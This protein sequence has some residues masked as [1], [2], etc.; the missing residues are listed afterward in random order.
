MLSPR[1]RPLPEVALAVGGVAMILGLAVLVSTDMSAGFDRGVIEL[2]RAPEL[3]GLLAPLRAVTELGSTWA[4][5]A[6]AVGVLAIGGLLGMWRHGLAGALTVTLAA[7]AN[8]SFKVVM[9]RQR[10]DLLDPVVV[11][12]GFSFPSGHS[13]T[14]MVAYGVLAVLVWRSALPAPVRVAVV[15]ASAVLIGLI[16]LSRVWLGVHY[17]TDVIAGWTVGAVLVVVYAAVSRRAWPAPA[18]A[19]AGAGRAGPRS[20]R[21]VPG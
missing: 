19:R 15:V 21:P 3:R 13:A 17:P 12:H 2:V 6:V 8:S 20:D 7:I 14:G 9:A 11:E 4:V 18:A 1:S 16:G 5:S 10:P